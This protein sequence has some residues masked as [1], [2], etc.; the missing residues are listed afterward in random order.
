MKW[1]G[2]PWP[3]PVLRAPV[4]EDDA[5]RIRT[6]LIACLRCGEYIKEGDQGIAMPYV[7]E[8]VLGR[9]FNEDG[10]VMCAYHLKC[11]LRSILGPGF[12]L[13]RLET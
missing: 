4:C 9:N 6:P 5:D 3:D 7:G 10:Q 2:E 12:D 1:F 11:Y 8:F 13:G